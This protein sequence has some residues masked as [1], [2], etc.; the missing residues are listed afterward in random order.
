MRWKLPGGYI[1][2]ESKSVGQRSSVFSTTWPDNRSATS[3]MTSTPSTLRLRNGWATTRRS[4]R[5]CWSGS[6]SPLQQRLRLLRVVA[7]PF[8]SL[9]VDGVEVIPDVADRLSGHVVEKTLERWPTALLSRPMYPPGNFH[10]IEFRDPGDPVTPLVRWVQAS[11]W[12]AGFTL[13]QSG[14]REVIQPV[15]PPAVVKQVVVRLDVALV[16]R[17]ELRVPEIPLR[18][19]E[20][21]DRVVDGAEVLGV[22]VRRRPLPD[23]LGT[24]VVGTEDL[25]QQRARQVAHVG[26]EVQEQR[27]AVAQQLADQHQT[28]VEHLEVG[29]DALA[30]G[31]AVGL[32]LDHRG[33]LGEVLLTGGAAVPDR[34]P[35]LVVLARVER[36]VDVDEVDLA[37]E[38]VCQGGEHVQVV[39]PDKPV[40]PRGSRAVVV[41]PA[42]E[43]RAPVGP[44]AVDRLDHLQRQV[45]AG[46]LRRLAVPLQPHAG[47][48]HLRGLEHPSCLTGVTHRVGDVPRGPPTHEA[49]AYSASKD[50]ASAAR[51]RLER[52]PPLPSANPIL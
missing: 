26:R 19:G 9:R 20:T 22:R 8:L 42:L 43:D 38:L 34:D 16:V 37:G 12:L 49:R 15:A 18:L 41:R 24:E 17:P 1:G 45:Q 39:A 6:S 3:G 47:H 27:P 2:R 7:Q 50:R 36:G 25:V 51:S 4:R 30:P 28:G 23:D 44:G 32:L 46:H 29:L 11:P 13:P 5:R 40:A 21:Q 48:Q 31:V 10:L 14:P 52:P 33:D 35:D